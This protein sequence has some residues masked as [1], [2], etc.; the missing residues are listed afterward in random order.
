MSM[1]TRRL[2]VLLDE[3][4]WIRLSRKAEETGQSVGALVR[5]A[6][7]RAYPATDDTRQAAAKSILSM[8]PMPVDDWDVMRREI[9][10]MYAG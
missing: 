9:D 4:R 8:K 5:D 2:Q 10:E 7:D 3:D 6:I 1:L